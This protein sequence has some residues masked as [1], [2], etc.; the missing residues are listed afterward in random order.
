MDTNPYAPPSSGV[1]P[2]YLATDIRKATLRELWRIAP[3]SLLG[4]LMVVVF[5]K[6]FR[7]T[8]PPTFGIAADSAF[9]C[10]LV[11]VQGLMAYHKDTIA[12]LERLGYLPE[13]GTKQLI[14]GNGFA[15]ELTFFGDDPTTFAI[16]SYTEIRTDGNVLQVGHLEFV[17]RNATTIWC[18]ANSQ[19]LF[20]NP[21]IF[22]IVYLTGIDAETLLDTHRE[23]MQPFRSESLR[24]FTP[25]VAWETQ[26]ESESF[27]RE[28]H[29]NRGVYRF[30]TNAEVDAILQ[31]E[32]TE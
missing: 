20:D 16:L 10:D 1:N 26:R 28:F 5:Q 18:T 24:R 19:H 31:S 15:N 7:L 23:R 21:P 13:F 2:E 32:A 12:T 14:L 8:S 11:E 6:V 22:K 3:P 30:M 29:L 25:E 27:M 9:R 4:K 17:S